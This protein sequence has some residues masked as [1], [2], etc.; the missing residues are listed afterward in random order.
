MRTLLRTPVPAGPHCIFSRIFGG[1]WTGDL[2]VKSGFR[3]FMACLSPFP[4]KPK[5]AELSVSIG[6]EQQRAE[7]LAACFS[8][9]ESGDGEFLL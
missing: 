7:V 8:L 2:S 5:I 3:R 1:F 4:L 6:A 9:S